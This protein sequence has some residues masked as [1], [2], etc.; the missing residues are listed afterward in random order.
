MKLAGLKQALTTLDAITFVLPDGEFVQPHFHVTEVGRRT[1]DFIDCG[2]TVRQ[3]SFATLQL[4]LADDIDHRLVP[5]KLLSIIELSEMK[6]KLQDLEVEVEYQADTVGRYTLDF[7]DNKFAMVP[8]ITNCP[9]PNKC[10]VPAAKEQPSCC[11]GD[12]CC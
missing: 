11:S 4:W 10:M 9:A 7:K 12:G 2:G 1:K 3:E 6:L 8:T 5:S